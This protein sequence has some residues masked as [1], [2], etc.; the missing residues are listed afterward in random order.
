MKNVILILGVLFVISCTKIE[1]PSTPPPVVAQ[2]EAL[3]F[4]TNIDTGAYY[5][6]DTLP[7]VVTVSSKLPSSGVM[8]SVVSTWTDSSK[9]IHKVDTTIMQSSASINI[10]GLKKEGTYSISVTITSK[11]TSSN[12]VSKNVTA[13]NSAIRNFTGYKVASNARLLGSDYWL[14]GTGVMTDLIIQTFQN[15]LPNNNSYAYQHNFINAGW[16]AAT[17]GDFNNDGYVD[18]FT[19]GSGD[20]IGLSFLIYD[21]NT[22]R[23]KDTSLINDKSL[24]LLP[25]VWKTVPTYLN[26]DNY[27]DL[28]IFA[29][30]SYDLPV[31]FLISDGKGGYDY[32]TF[33]VK[34]KVQSSCCGQANVFGLGGDA[35]DLNKDGFIDL[36][37]AADNFVFIY[38]GVSGSQYFKSDNYTLYASDTNNFPNVTNIGSE[39]SLCSEK[40]GDVIIKDVNNDNKLDL[41]LLVGENANVNPRILMNPGNGLFVNSN[42]VK[43]P[44]YGREI[45]LHDYMHDESNGDVIAQNGGGLNNIFSYWNIYKY[46]KNNGTYTLDTTSIKFNYNTKQYD[47]NKGR[48]LYYD[49]NKDGIKDIGYVD[50]SWGG[51]NGTF[52]PVTRQGNIMP[53]KTVFIKRG[54]LYIEEDYFQYDPYAKSLLT[55]LKNRFK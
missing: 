53:F 48:L 7:L 16:T 37:I 13:I 50:A 40:V 11:S 10:P 20:Y 45:E 52:N 47:G 23:F 19:P 12:T 5:V 27:V 35:G 55:I 3:K 30:D 54:D 4:T 38:W 18:V 39:C 31:R 46:K 15:P 28:I 34:H 43:L 9:Q 44:L 24:K 26:S 21:V 2:E 17:C 42:V 32:S 36:V 41:L 1:K 22:K 14:R 8:V 29:G 25:L 49:Y 51:N 6:I 33:D